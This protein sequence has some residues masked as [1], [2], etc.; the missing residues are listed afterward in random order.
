MGGYIYRRATQS[1]IERYTQKGNVSS[2][3]FMKEGGPASSACLLA[4]SKAPVIYY[5]RG[6]DGG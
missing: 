6:G 2:Y 3:I 1:R 4:Q 5:G